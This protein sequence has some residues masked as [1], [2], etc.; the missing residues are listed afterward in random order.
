MTFPGR[1]ACMLLVVLGASAC[2]GRPPPPTRGVIEA[3]VSAWEFRRYQELLDIEVLVPGNQAVA[4]TASYAHKEA[5]KRGRVTEADITHVFVTRYQRE[6][7]ILRALVKFARRLA[8]ESGYTVEERK[9]SGVRLFHV[10]GHG[11]TWVL[12]AAP[13][14]IVKV[15]GHGRDSVPGDLVEAY[16]ERYPS[17]V[18]PGMLEGPLPPGDEETP[19]GEPAGEPGDEDIGGPR[20]DWDEY[21]PD[22]VKTPESR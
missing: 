22:A 5:V 19:P 11:E 10:T 14:H 15:G 8:Q 7:G 12:W 17:R 4:H 16:G 6:P 2:G 13:T 18:Q 1:V 21:D 9:L 3:D 20:P